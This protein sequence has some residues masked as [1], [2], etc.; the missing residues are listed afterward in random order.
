MNEL[1]HPNAAEAPFGESS[2]CVHSFR[3]RLGGAVHEAGAYPH[4]KIRSA[5]A[6][7]EVVYGYH[8]SPRIRGVAL[9][10]WRALWTRAVC[11][12]PVVPRIQARVGLAWPAG[13]KGPRGLSMQP[14]RQKAG[15]WEGRYKL[16]TIGRSG[17]RD[18]SS[19]TT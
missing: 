10:S 8:H 17:Y 16:M 4:R 5:P 9:S 6:L 15:G 18:C 11:V 13:I 19:V 2:T 14:S 3:L 7:K 1:R 12:Y